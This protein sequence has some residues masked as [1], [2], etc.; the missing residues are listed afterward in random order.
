MDVKQSKPALSSD[1]IA[2]SSLLERDGRREL[3]PLQNYIIALL[4][5][6]PVVEE[7]TD[8]TQSFFMS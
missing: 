1:R 6:A 8:T 5:V 3:I 7:T 4:P 2:V